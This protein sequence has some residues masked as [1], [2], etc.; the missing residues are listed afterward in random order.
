MT[1]TETI[2]CRKCG[3]TMDPTEQVTSP[4]DGPVIHFYVCARCDLKAVVMFEAVGGGTD[5]QQTWVEQ[6]V[7]RRGSFFPNDWT[8]ASR[9]PRFGG[10]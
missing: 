3:D 10:G 6:E 4:G 1:S 9:G 8:G 5:E 7:G 2:A